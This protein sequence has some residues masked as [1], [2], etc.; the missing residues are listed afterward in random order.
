MSS[1][2]YY[3][4]VKG[5][6]HVLYFYTICLMLFNQYISLDGDPVQAGQRKGIPRFGLEHEND[7]ISL[8]TVL[9]AQVANT[10]QVYNDSTSL[11]KC[12]CI[13]STECVYLKYKRCHVNFSSLYEISK[14]EIFE[15]RQMNEPYTWSNEAKSTKPPK[16]KS[17]G[18]AGIW[19]PGLPIFVGYA[20]HSTTEPFHLDFLVFS[21]C[22]IDARETKWTQS[23]AFWKHTP[24]RGMR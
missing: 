19:T 5:D 6:V 24:P 7:A 4:S 8:R 22:L 11:S 18:G 20:N 21:I 3:H 15:N 9:V 10:S 16:D 17:C 13:R 14:E 12:K 23:R 1:T 2:I